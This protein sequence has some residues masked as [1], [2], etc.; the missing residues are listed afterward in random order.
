[1]KKICNYLEM[2][3]DRIGTRFE[4]NPFGVTW[5]INSYS[6]KTPDANYD[7]WIKNQKM[8][9]SICERF[10]IKH[11]T[12]HQ[13]NLSNGKLNKS[14]FEKEHLLNICYCGV[15][16]QSIEDNMEQAIRFRRRVRAEAVLEDGWLVDLANVFDDVDKD[17]YID[18]LHV[19]E[20]G[21]RIIADEIFN[22]LRTKEYI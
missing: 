6:T 12:V 18:R 17:V 4:S 2:Q 19:N 22:I 15:A 14:T 9:H 11:I 10:N 8:I 5:G 16:R 21:N 1:M 20:E 7:F 3:N 13:P